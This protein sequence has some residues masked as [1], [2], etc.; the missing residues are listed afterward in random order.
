MWRTLS[1]K[2][3]TIMLSIEMS[4]SSN[5]HLNDIYLRRLK[6]NMIIHLKY[7]LFLH[8]PLA[9]ELAKRLGHVAA[10]VR[11]HMNGLQPFESTIEQTIETM[12]AP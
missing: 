3:L 5:R 8:E 1:S 10:L 11:S 12:H 6:A 2:I 4:D 7:N 9:D